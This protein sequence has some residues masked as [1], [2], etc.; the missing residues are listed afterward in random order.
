M[1]NNGLGYYKDKFKINGADM[2]SLGEDTYNR[3]TRMAYDDINN[4]KPKRKASDF[5]NPKEYELYK[6][7][8]YERALAIEKGLDKYE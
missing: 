3:V 4:R 8:L 1:A 2:L 6:A 7:T 5:K